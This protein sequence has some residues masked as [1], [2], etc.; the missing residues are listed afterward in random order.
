[1]HREYRVSSTILV[2]YGIVRYRSRCGIDPALV[3]VDVVAVLG[4][5]FIMY[6][7]AFKPF[8]AIGLTRHEEYQVRRDEADSMAGLPAHTPASQPPTSPVDH[9]L[10]TLSKNIGTPKISRSNAQMSRCVI[11][12]S[13][14]R[15]RL[16]ARASYESARGSC[17]T[18]KNVVFYS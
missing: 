17:R 2:S 1:M 6:M 7:E 3:C 18:E 12:A 14:G 16:F 5:N 4:E 10:L 9:A 15:V 8:L 13:C 11:V